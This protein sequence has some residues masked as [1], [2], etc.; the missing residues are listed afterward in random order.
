MAKIDFDIRFPLPPKQPRR[1]MEPTLK[2]WLT[3]A[4]V[5]V[6]LML[7]GWWFFR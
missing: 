2:G 6:V 4:M 3:L 5:P 1:D 7:I